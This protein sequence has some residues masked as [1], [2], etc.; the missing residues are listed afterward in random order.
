[1]FTAMHAQRYQR[2]ALI[3]DIEAR[4]EG[5]VLLCYVSGA[6]AE[7]DRDDTVGFAELLHKVPHGTSIDL[8]LH[9]PGGD[10]DAAEKL[11]TM[12][13]ATV[14]DAALRVIVPDYAKS[15]GTLIALGGNRIVMSDT[16][17]LG[18]IDPQVARSDG[19]GTDIVHSVLGYID[20]FNETEAAVQAHPDDP[21]K[22]I[23]FDKF[24]PVVLRQYKAI[25]RRARVFAE[26]QLKPRGLNYSK[27]VSDLM[28]INRF[29]SHGQMINWET[30]SEIIGLPVDY[31]PKHDELWKLYWT[32]YCHLR[33][34]VQNNQKI[35]ESYYV[36]LV[37]DFK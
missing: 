15:A 18:T 26:N 20:A 28:D 21:A 10:V 17:E 36:S 30:A 6:G 16:S 33:L 8:L 31:L 29:P 3:R 27:I 1:M 9:T 22:R 5:R 19:C 32:L 13:Q 34:A 4:S 7:V 12:V 25:M 11:I 23:M 2:Q 35:F 24:D 14:G 37:M